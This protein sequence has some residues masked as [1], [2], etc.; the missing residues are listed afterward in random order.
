MLEAH[1]MNLDSWVVAGGRP[2]TPGEPLNPPLSTV[3]TFRRGGDR[4]YARGDGTPT[5]SALEELIGGMEGGIATA[6]SSGLAAAAAVFDTLSAGATVAIPEGGY[7][8]VEELALAGESRGR[9]SVQQIDFADTPAWVE[10][11]A[12]TDLIWLESPSNPMLA[13]A[14]LAPICAATRKAGNIIGVDN[15]FAT[16]FNQRPLEFGADVVMHSATKFIG[17]HSDLLAGAVVTNRDDLA[18][19]FALTRKQTGALPG[20]LE[21]YLAVRGAR[22]MAVRLERGQASALV[23]A[24]RLLD[25]PHIDTVR[26]PG[27]PSDPYHDIASRVLDGFGAV[28]TFDVAGGDEAAAAVCAKIELISHATSLGGVEST[29]ERRAAGPDGLIRLSVGCENVEDLW[30]DLVQ[31]LE[32]G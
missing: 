29:M 25:S 19:D 5:I 10:A 22:T 32:P 18:A 24:G 31:A 14:D 26:Y 15:T 17:G 2:Q 27:L 9:W 7:H 13:V 4:S 6:F 16:S 21:A 30:S 12:H 11:V 28:I 3:S 8:G 1:Q 20:S 23:L